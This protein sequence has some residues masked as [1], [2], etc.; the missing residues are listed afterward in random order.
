MTHFVFPCGIHAH[1]D[2]SVLAQDVVDAADVIDI[3]TV[4]AVVECDAANI[5][6]KFFVDTPL[7]W[8]AAFK[9]KS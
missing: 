5:G 8:L 9:A 3:I 2:P 1:Q 6:T 4:Q 7:E